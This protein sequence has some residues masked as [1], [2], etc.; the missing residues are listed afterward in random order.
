MTAQ[1]AARENRLRAGGAKP[2]ELPVPLPLAASVKLWAGA[3]VA[4]DTA[5]NA[6]PA[7]STAGNS[8]VTVGVS[9]RTVDNSAGI[10]GAVKTQGVRRGIVE[11][12][13]LT[14]DPVTAASIG[15]NVYAA[16]DQTVAATSG[17]ATRVVA[18]KLWGFDTDSGKPLVEVG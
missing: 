10:A 2:D 12:E 9:E 15:R 3:F 8:D 17:G 16:D 13:N 5:G 1:A 7:R 11:A 4:V 18:G 14:G 6:R